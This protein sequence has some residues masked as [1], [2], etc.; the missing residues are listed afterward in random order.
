MAKKGMV[1]REIKRLKAYE[2]FK[3]KRA[4]LK[5]QAKDT[6]LPPE[7]RFMARLKLA[8]LPRASSKI[9]QHN[10][11]ELTGRPHGY[12]RRLGLSRIALREL[13]SA[14]KIPGMTKSSW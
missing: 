3:D 1:Q 11:C 12:Y 2:R 5:A 14:G 8:K 10:R 7:E 9:R 13:G 6:N 4:A